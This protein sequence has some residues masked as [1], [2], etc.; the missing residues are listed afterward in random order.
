MQTWL[1]SSTSLGPHADEEISGAMRSG[2]ERKASAVNG[3]ANMVFMMPV[4]MS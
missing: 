3:W 1:A 4:V 2:E